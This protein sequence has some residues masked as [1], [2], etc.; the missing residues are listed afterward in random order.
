METLR[1]R[2]NADSENATSPLEKAARWLFAVRRLDIIGERLTVRRLDGG[3]INILRPY[4]QVQDTAEGQRLTFTAELPSGL[5]DRLQLN[6]ERQRVDDADPEAGRG[7]F[8]FE[9]GR[10]NLAG[11][12][13]P[14]PFSAGQVGLAVSGDWRDWRP[15]R[16]QGQLRLRQARP[17]PEPRT[18]LLASWLAATPDSELNFE[19]NTQDAGWRLRARPGLAMVI[20]RARRN[21]FRAE[22]RRWA[23]ARGR[24]RLARSG[25]AG[26]GDAV[27]GRVG[28]KLAGVA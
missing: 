24:P 11:W 19:W 17:K 28:P 8:R 13:L 26:L 12:P 20:P 1:L 18:T 10:L 4:F 25:R 22:S 9:A 7:T 21:P 5:G 27:A 6:V 14:L 2:A 3:A 16:L 23:L 15:V